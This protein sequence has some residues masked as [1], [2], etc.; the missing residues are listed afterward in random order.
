MP[1]TATAPESKQKETPSVNA[2]LPPGSL[3]LP[4]LGETLAF[5]AN[6]FAFVDDRV[7]KY[8]PIFKTRVL[9]RDTIV[10]S[11]PEAARA[12]LDP[13][14]CL[15]GKPL[16]NVRTLFGGPSLPML[17]GKTHRAR[18]TLVLE[19]FTNEAL[20][21][22]LPPM[23][24]MIESAVDDWTKRGE[25]RWLDELM[26]LA[27][28]V[29]FA[30]VTSTS[31]GPRLDAVRADYR[32]LQLAFGAL[33]INFPG[34]A[35]HRALKARDR[36]LDFYRELVTEHRRAPNGDGL[37]RILGAKTSEGV[38]IANEEAV[39]EL[40]HI[41]VAGFIIF[42]EFADSVR[43]LTQAPAVRDA[44]TREIRTQLPSGALSIEAIERLPI[45]N[46]VIMETKRLCHILPVIFGA[47]KR[48]FTFNGYTVPEGWMLLWGLRSSHLD[49]KIYREPHRFDP[50]RFA[51]P[52]AE[53]ELHEHAFVP[54]GPGPQLGHK[55]PGTDYATLFMKAFLVC[56]LRRHHWELP[57]Q[58]FD[59]SFKI[60]PPEPKDGLR[61]RLVVG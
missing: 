52:R 25:F 53:H 49:P 13:E 47:A 39:L 22:F 44:L 4:G 60:T 24:R 61:A 42:C 32:M 8:G 9:G 40:H 45:L 3:G 20:R 14:L 50:D 7:A 28:E 29:I 16:P 15:R 5:A 54:H 26:N 11:G 48:T 38:R 12:F 23:Q 37:S 19:G 57:A 41:I 59:Y 33:P 17:D 31:P 30:N 27:M 58:N 46:R 35:F 10:I 6:G 1:S 36:I 18:K 43:H 51:P 34:T 2:P 56:V 55:C 21:E